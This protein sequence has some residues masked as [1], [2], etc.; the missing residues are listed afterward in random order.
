M[1]FEEKYKKLNKEQKIAVDSIEEPVMVIAGPGTGKTSILTMRIANILKQTDTP[2]SG[3]LAL[4]FT[5]AGQKEMKRRLLDLIGTRAL[6]VSI[7][8]YHGFA[9]SVIAEFPEHFP[10]LSRSK[11]IDEIESD[12]IIR[13]I[14]K[15][16]KFRKLRPLGDP[17]LY[18]NP[19]SRTISICKREAWTPEII[20]NFAKEEIKRTESDENLISSRGAT[21]GQLKA[22]A[23]KQIE[24]CE[25]TMLFGKVYTEYEIKKQKLRKIDYDDLIFELITAM[26]KDELLLRLLQERYLHILVDEHQDTNEAQNLLIKTIADFFETPNLFIVGDE[27]QAI[28]RFQGASVNNFLK[29]KETWKNMKTIPLTRN[30]RSHQSILDASFSMIENNYRKGEHEELRIKLAADGNR[31]KRP[32][33][34]VYAEN[35]EAADQYLVE[36]VKKVSEREPGTSISIIVRRNRDVEKILSL[37]EKRGIN[38]KAERGVDIFKDPIGIAFFSLIEALIDS[39]KLEELAKTINFGL[40]NL[41]FA[42]LTETIKKIRSGNIERIEKDIPA[43]FELKK[44]MH[45]LSAIQYLIHIAKVSGL[46][47]L[48]ARNARFAEVWRGII[49]LAK[50]IASQK[51]IDDPKQLI[52]ELLSFKLASEKRSIKILLGVGDEKIQVMTAHSSKGLEFDYV[53]LPYAN[54]EIWLSKGHGSFFVLPDSGL[55]DESDEARDARRLFYVAITRTKKHL[56]I[57]IPLEEGL[58]RT[59]TPVRFIA[60]IDK[61]DIHEEN[62]RALSSDESKNISIERKRKTELINYAKRQLLENGLSVTAL[63]HYVNCPNRFF[64]KSIL[65]LPEPP[66]G[67]SEKGNAMHEAIAKVWHISNRSAAKIT[68][69]IQDSVKEYFTRSFLSLHDKESA[70]EE[71]MSDA[72]KI[73]KSLESH[74]NQKEEVVHT[75]YWIEAIHGK[76]KIHGRLDALIENNGNIKVFDYKT[77]RPKSEAEVKGETKNGD[78]NYF[79]QLVFYKIL[80]DGNISFRGKETGLNLV[81]LKPDKKEECKTLALKVETKDIQKVKGEINDLVEAV[82]SGKILEKLCDDKSCE[83]CAY[84]KLLKN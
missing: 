19:I 51:S 30:Y 15:D 10:H 8:T 64:Y 73:A 23:K 33:D 69:A 38:A 28:F 58:E 45:E 21:K 83:Y 25:R 63:N 81:F 59:M 18:V 41:N 1:D 4:T 43:F 74:F 31:E 54:E 20:E 50:S 37:F 16:V 65:K 72:P 77:G 3:I 35:E 57:I 36:E 67:S 42:K 49:T 53:F 6:E 46:T 55:K 61:K 29:F 12:E 40:W 7:F 75:E 78:G 82:W 68:D 27:K 11:Q 80:L 56:S 9:A 14:L 22:E 60:E 62:L 32:I 70:I 17:D 84:R 47:E 13:E 34:V 24:K 52:E 79:R 71:L 5:E 2:P 66:T 39:S 76:I 26:K 48:V 44:D